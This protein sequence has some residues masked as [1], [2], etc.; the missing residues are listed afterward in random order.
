MNDKPTNKYR[1]RRFLRQE[2]KIVNFDIF[3]SYEK[4]IF[5]TQRLERKPETYIN[6]RI[7]KKGDVTYGL[8]FSM[9]STKLLLVTSLEINY[10]YT[11]I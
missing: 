3:C 1:L 8:R 7:L 10:N 11:F 6:I 5:E 4:H 2:I 9:F